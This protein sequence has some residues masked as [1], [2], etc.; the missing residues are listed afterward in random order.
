MLALE[1]AAFDHEIHIASL[2]GTGLEKFH[3]GVLGERVHRSEESFVIV[4]FIIV[5]ECLVVREF[6]SNVS[7]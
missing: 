7:R 6:A 3:R 4:C 2:H 5:I 1:I